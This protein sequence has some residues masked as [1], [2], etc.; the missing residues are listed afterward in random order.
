MK[1]GLFTTSAH[2][3]LVIINHKTLCNLGDIVFYIPTKERRTR[4]WGLLVILKP[5]KLDDTNRNGSV[6]R[7]KIL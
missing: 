6:C 2:S 3:S 4:Y 7:N 5:D 1:M